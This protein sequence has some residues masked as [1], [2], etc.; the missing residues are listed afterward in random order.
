[1][2]SP[3]IAHM[4]GRRTESRKLFVWLDVVVVGGVDVFEELL[5]LL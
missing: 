3:L 1:M 2:S 5:T 4:T